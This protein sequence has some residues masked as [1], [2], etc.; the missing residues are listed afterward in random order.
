MPIDKY[1]NSSKP[2]FIFKIYNKI[3]KDRNEMPFINN[4]KKHKINYI[5]FNNNIGPFYNLRII[6]RISKNR[7]SKYKYSD[8]SNIYQSQEL[9]HKNGPI[10]NNRN[11]INQNPKS[12]KGPIDNNKDHFSN[13][14]NEN[15]QEIIM[16]NQKEIKL[17]NDINNKNNATNNINKNE[18]LTIKN[19]NNKEHII[20]ANKYHQIHKSEIKLSI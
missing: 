13:D 4:N 12:K 20:N 7:N 17:K 2:I 14:I 19:N 10:D 9:V 5:H 18:I 3:P 16:N 8:N 11:K 6:N 1:R 15:V